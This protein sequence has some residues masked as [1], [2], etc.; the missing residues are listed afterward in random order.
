MHQGPIRGS[1][2]KQP[3]TH[4]RMR[5]LQGPGAVSARRRAPTCITC[6]VRQDA[7]SPGEVGDSQC[8]VAVR[9]RNE[10]MFSKYDSGHSRPI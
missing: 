5:K 1:T 3:E 8:P 4:H 7:C 2:R 9:A 6:C 10:N